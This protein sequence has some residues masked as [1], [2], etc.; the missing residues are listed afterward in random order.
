MKTMLQT[1]LTNRKGGVSKDMLIKIGLVIIAVG[2]AVIVLSPMI[3]NMSTATDSCG[4]FRNWI[5][6]LSSGNAELC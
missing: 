4:A 5:T 1:L 3:Q 2:V 6:D